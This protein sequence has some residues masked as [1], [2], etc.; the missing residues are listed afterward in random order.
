VGPVLDAGPDG[1][2]VLDAIRTLNRDVEV[3][4][5]GSYLRVLVPGRC[6]VTREA[7][8]AARGG[9]F[10]LPADLEMVMPSFKGR[11]TVDEEAA[12]WTAEGPG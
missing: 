2:A 8:E 7:I 9:S 6:V 5:R 3:E 11:F 1:A 4:D 12:V 10:R